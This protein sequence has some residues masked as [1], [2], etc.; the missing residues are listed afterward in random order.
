[1]AEL[2]GFCSGNI[3]SAYTS[4]HGKRMRGL[5]LE[6]GRRARPGP[7]AALGAKCNNISVA[8]SVNYELR[9]EHRKSDLYQ[10]Q[11]WGAAPASSHVVQSAPAWLGRQ[12]RLR[13]GQHADCVNLYDV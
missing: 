9:S 12:P 10:L 13:F 3:N 1:V 7:R 8:L 4:R 11:H 2:E 5:R 6:P